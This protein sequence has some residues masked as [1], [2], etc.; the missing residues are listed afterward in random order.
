M[1]RIC[2]FF[3]AGIVLSIYLPD[4]ISQS[5]IIQLIL[6]LTVA[7]VILS[8]FGATPSYSKILSGFLGLS[9]I[10]FSGYL[11]LMQK[12]ES[13]KEDH[14]IY[15]K[16]KIELYEGEVVSSLDE[17]PKSW[18]LLVEVK[19]IKTASAWQKASGKVQVYISKK[20]GVPILHYKDRLLIHA[21]PQIIKSAANPGEFDFKRFLSFRNIYHQQ[22]IKL[23]QVKI[24]GN[25]RY[26]NLVYYSYQIRAWASSIIKKYISGDREQAITSALVLGVTDGIDT[27]LIDAY[28][29]S[30]AMHVLSVS[31]LHVG[32]IYFLLM[33]LL[34]PIS[35]FAWSR[36]LLAVFTII[37]LWAYAF[38]TGLSPSVLRAVMMFSFMALAK[39]LGWRT[40]IYNTLASSAFILLLYDP[41]LVMSVGF[42]LSYIAVI[43]IVYLQRPLYNLWEPSSW[44]MDNI[45]QITCVSIAAQ[46]A[47]FSLGLLYFHQFPVYFLFS[48]LIVIPLSTLVLLVGIMLMVV[49]SLSW[50]ASI[51]GVALQWMIK[52][53]NGS[54][55]FVEDLPFS[56]I[57]NVYISTFQSWLLIGI[58]VFVTMLF[59]QKEFK[60][61]ML[62]LGC[63]L[64]FSLLQW[65][66]FFDDVKANQL[67]VYQIPAHNAVEFMRNGQSY[68]FADS[69]LVKDENKIHFHINPNR[70]N[71]GV[72][73]IHVN[74]IKFAKELD[75]F[76]YF[77]WQNKKVLWITKRNYKLP[78]NL[79]ADLLIVSN[80]AYPS[81]QIKINGLKEIVLDGSCKKKII[82]SDSAS[83]YFTPIQQAFVKKI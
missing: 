59:L 46:L 24:V 44:L 70:L 33:L 79:Y 25:I 77:V 35:K 58:V 54:V 8:L 71:S 66:H 14:I 56:L 16:E 11:L 32:I 12:T 31:G 2:L 41:Y 74:D 38:V 60:F 10:F 78:S 72:S 73:G 51:V 50:M 80:D 81:H 63:T 28:S 3:I 64:L 27:E 18:K 21:S 30:G 82:Q 67:V 57:N 20:S 62:S 65:I 76:R 34:K 26:K 49:S 5:I 75:G 52:L 83:V 61:L 29:A 15:V 45:W 4:L 69:M 55:F 47:T 17:K 42:Q 36:W 39:P 48:N 53:L 40:N 68:F 13:R 23:S 22:F 1:V 6:A 7:Y 43:G 19:R 9:F 37:L